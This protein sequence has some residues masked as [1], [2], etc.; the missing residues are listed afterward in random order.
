MAVA[1]V[2]K[3]T[4][5]NVRTALYALKAHA[6]L[7]A[8]TRA[9][10]SIRP[11]SSRDIP[12][13]ALLRAPRPT[14]RRSASAAWRWVPTG[15]SQEEL[16]RLR[17]ARV[18]AP[19]VGRRRTSARPARCLRRL[20]TTTSVL[21]DAPAGRIVGAYRVAPRGA[22]ARRTSIAWPL[23]RLPVDRTIP[24]AC[25]R[26][27]PKAWNSGAASA[28]RAGSLGQPQRRLVVAGSIGAYLREHPRVRY[29][30]GAVS[31]SAALPPAARE[32]DHRVLR[33]VL[34]R[35]AACEVVSRRPCR[36]SPPRRR[37]WPASTQARQLALLKADLSKP[38][39]PRC[40][41]FTSNTPNCA[42]P[43]ARVSSPSASIRIS[44][45]HRRID[46]GR[47][48][49]H[50]P[51]QAQAISARNG[52]IQRS[53]SNIA[54]RSSYGIGRSNGRVTSPSRNARAACSP[55]AKACWNKPMPA[56]T[57][58]TPARCN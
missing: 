5:R 13:P 48:R 25:C 8:S 23:H 44:R 17:E 47:H 46:R 10:A 56:L 22:G 33:A 39:A 1:S 50:A 2:D 31:I 40:R 35:Y 32:Q 11:S 45:Q 28:S 34:R 4:V 26:A 53:D 16:G 42:N 6:V 58:R 51:P 55:A 37:R 14:A 54:L 41:C 38:S 15:C 27:S 36:L 12:V 21:W 18:R 7:A 30:F 57:R 9:A 43:A 24:S 19:S 29:L 52:L 49:A 3:A 20:S